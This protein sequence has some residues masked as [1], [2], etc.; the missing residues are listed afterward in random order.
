MV[1]F[2]YL[3]KVEQRE[4]REPYSGESEPLLDDE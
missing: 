4:R 3:N 2:S 1:D